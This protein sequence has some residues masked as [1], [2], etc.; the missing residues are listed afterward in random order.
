VGG[1]CVQES[2]KV[3]LSLA[4]ARIDSSRRKIEADMQMQAEQQV[5]RTHC[6]TE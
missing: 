6:A 5:G 3:E 4:E 2:L 1:P